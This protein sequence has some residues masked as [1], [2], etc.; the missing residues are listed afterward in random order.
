MRW[1][2]EILKMIKGNNEEHAKMET[3]DKQEEG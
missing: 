2:K 1:L 3:S